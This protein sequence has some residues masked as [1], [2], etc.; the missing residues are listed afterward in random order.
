MRTGKQSEPI[1]VEPIE[2]PFERR[3]E[4]PIPAPPV[5]TPEKEPVP[6]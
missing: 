5:R 4:V 6:S 1:V 3:R 2:D